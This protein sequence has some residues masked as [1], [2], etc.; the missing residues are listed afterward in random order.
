MQSSPS[1]ADLHEIQG[2]ET[3]LTNDIDLTFRPENERDGLE[4]G[5]PGGPRSP[6]RADA[7]ARLPPMTAHAV[8]PRTEV[9]ADGAKSMPTTPMIDTQDPGPGAASEFGIR[10]SP[11]AAV[12]KAF[13]YS[14]GG[15][16]VGQAA[17]AAALQRMGETA[18]GSPAGASAAATGNAAGILDGGGSVA[19]DSNSEGGGASLTNVSHEEAQLPTF[20]KI[21]ADHEA[22]IEDPHKKSHELT[23]PETAMLEKDMLEG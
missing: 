7:D 3:K 19:S 4:A 14:E 17:A 22:G 12:N 1:V 20:W 10:H 23:F 13:D 11:L 6:P 5:D 2:E 21:K 8:R 18:T 16:E 15:G 9:A